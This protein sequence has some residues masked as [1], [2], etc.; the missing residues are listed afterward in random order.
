MV[1]GGAK[2]PNQLLPY[3]STTLTWGLG[4]G[5]GKRSFHL[6]PRPKD[7]SSGSSILYCELRES[8]I[9]VIGWGVGGRR[10]FPPTN[11]PQPIYTRILC[12]RREVGKENRKPLSPSH[13]RATCI[14]V[15][16]GGWGRKE[17]SSASFPHP[18]LISTRTWICCLRLL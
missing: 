1:L 4:R 18:P 9:E 17:R 6:L 11:K 2:L 13:P 8:C 3:I 15:Y 5:G 14:R 16:K 12:S 10:S 7:V